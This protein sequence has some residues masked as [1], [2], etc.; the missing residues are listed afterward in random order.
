[1]SRIG[2]AKREGLNAILSTKFQTNYAYFQIVMLAYNILRY[3]KM[4]VQLSIGDNQCVQ[5]N[6]GAKGL[7]GIMNNTIPIVPP[8]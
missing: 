2:E 5:A 7:Q 1:L 8:S 6:Q 3:L 4:I